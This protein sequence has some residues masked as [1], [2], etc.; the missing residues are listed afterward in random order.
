M[1]T[2]WDEGRGIAGFSPC[3]FRLGAPVPIS[4]RL[5]RGIVARIP[6]AEDQLTLLGRIL[7]HEV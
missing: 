7:V 1:E 3:T 2:E 6:M 4:R 5:C